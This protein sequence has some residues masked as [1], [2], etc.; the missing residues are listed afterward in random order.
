[1][2]FNYYYLFVIFIYVILFLL[3]YFWWKKGR[4]IFGFIIVIIEL[5]LQHKYSFEAYP[6]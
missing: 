5:Y 1:M 4:W 3:V 2:F 6:M